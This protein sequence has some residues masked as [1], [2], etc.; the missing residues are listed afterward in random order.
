[1]AAGG[2][3]L[4]NAQSGVFVFQC[5]SNLIGGMPIAAGNF[6][7][8]N[9]LHGVWL[10]NSST[11]QNTVQNNLIGFGGIG[12]GGKGVLITGS[13]NN[14]I[15][16]ASGGNIIAFN[17]GPGAAVVVGTNN[18]ITLNL[19]ISNGGLGI[20]LDDNGITPND[21]GDGDTGSNNLQNFPVLSQATGGMTTLIPG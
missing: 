2:A 18:S 3:A 16:G 13:S 14:L 5:P 8:G 9:T 7:A 20:D 19:F 21:A 17:G 15:G 1:N 4:G 10:S 11:G 12:N 6:I